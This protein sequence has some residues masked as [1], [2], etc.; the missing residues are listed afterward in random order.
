MSRHGTGVDWIFMALIILIG[1]FGASI[2]ISINTW[3]S[4]FATGRESIANDLCGYYNAKMISHDDLET[5]TC[6]TDNEVGVTFV[7]VNKHNAS[8]QKIDR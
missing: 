6:K 8:W 1:L 2:G 5:I 7:L 3:S 4:R